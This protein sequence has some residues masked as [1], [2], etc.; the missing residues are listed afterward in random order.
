LHRLIKEGEEEDVIQ[1]KWAYISLI[2]RKL[3]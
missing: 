1:A 3:R 2:T